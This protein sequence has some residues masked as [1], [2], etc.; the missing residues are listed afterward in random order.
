MNFPLG[1]LEAIGLSVLAVI[2]ILA[3]IAIWGHHDGVLAERKRMAPVI[4]GYEL[5]IRELVA[6]VTDL[7]RDLKAQNRKVDELKAQADVREKAAAAALKAARTQA[8]RYRLRAA[9]IAAA[10]PTG[11]QC[12]AARD[13]IVKTLSEDRQ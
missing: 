8:D 7:E 4:A 3:G 2:A 1:R 9:E 6:Q 13:L 5:R 12:L 11:D 10:K